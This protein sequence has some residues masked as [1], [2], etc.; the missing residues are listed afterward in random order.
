MDRSVRQRGPLH[1]RV[2]T[3]WHWLSM[4]SGPHLPSKLH[5]RH[6]PRAVPRHVLRPPHHRRHRIRSLLPFTSHHHPHP[7][8][9]GRTSRRTLQSRHRTDPQHQHHHRMV[10]PRQQRSRLPHP[11]LL[12]TGRP[13]HHSQRPT[14]LHFL[15]RLRPHPWRN[16]LLPHPGHQRRPLRRSLQPDLRKHPPHHAPTVRPN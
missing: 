9:P 4:V 16:L 8:L 12:L 6:G 5:R 15:Q 10:R 2:P 13:S 7:R 1:Y 3:R 11:P 14:Q